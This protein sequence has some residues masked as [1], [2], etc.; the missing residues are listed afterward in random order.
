MAKPVKG[1]GKIS[2]YIVVA[3]Y[4]IPSLLQLE[5]FRSVLYKTPLLQ[6][7]A[8]LVTYIKC[9]YTVRMWQLHTPW[10]HLPNYVYC[11]HSTASDELSQSLEDFPEDT[12]EN[13]LIVTLIKYL[14]I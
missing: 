14:T 2:Y 1:L 7:V 9:C 5:R 4:G 11:D 3:D 12:L 6:V 13:L 10:Y 8:D